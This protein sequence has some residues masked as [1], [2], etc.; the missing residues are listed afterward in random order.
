MN[1]YKNSLTLLTRHKEL[2]HEANKFLKQASKDVCTPELTANCLRDALNSIGGIT[3]KVTPD[4]VLG[5]IF[6]S[7]CIGK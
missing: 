4:E 2:L 3:G 7:F 1:P 5:K 6:S